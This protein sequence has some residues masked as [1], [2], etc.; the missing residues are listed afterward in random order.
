[1]EIQLAQLIRTEDPEEV[2]K[3]VKS[4]FVRF[5]PASSFLKIEHAFRKTVPLFSGGY[6]GYKA[7]N[8]EYHNLTHTLDAFL[9]TARLMDGKNITEAPFT[10]TTAQRLLIAALLHDSGYIQKEGDTGTGAKYTVNHVERSVAF[11][12]ANAEHFS[13]GND[14]VDEIGTI[15]F[16]TGLKNRWEEIPFTSSEA[17]KAG[18]V[19]ASADIL[20]QMSDRQ[21]LEKLLFLYREFKEA[22]IPGFDTEF[23][24][25]RKT[26]EFYEG[27]KTRLEKTLMSAFEYARPHFRE[28]HGVDRNLYIEAIERQIAYLREIISDETTNFRHKLK[29]IDL[30]LTEM[31]YMA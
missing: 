27:T 21:Y 15:I 31:Q 22:D 10:E 13:L 2:L 17:M 6:P 23:D 8:T 19:L 24:I 28:R 20:G 14:D 25:L 5:Y 7:C 12:R 29:R 16:C 18:A 4:L 30:E 26:E 9:A 11:V 1:M 3:T